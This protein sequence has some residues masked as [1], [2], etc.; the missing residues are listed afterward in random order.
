MHLSPEDIAAAE[1]CGIS[2][3][4]ASD[5]Q[6]QRLAMQRKVFY[7]AGAPILAT[8]GDGLFETAGTLLQLI[9]EGRQQQH[10]L[11]QWLEPPQSATGA[12]PEAVPEPDM[13]KAAPRA[14][15]CLPTPATAE[16]LVP[17]PKRQLQKRRRLDMPV[18][19]APEPAALPQMVE[20]SPD[21]EA[22]RAESEGTS[23]AELLV[24][25]PKRQLQKQRRLD[26]PVPAAPELAA[27]PQMVEVEPLPDGEA[28]RAES[29]GT[30]VPPTLS[31]TSGR[32]AARTP[33]TRVDVSGQD[34][35]KRWL[36][37][38]AT[39]RGRAGKHWSTRQR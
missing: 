10:D 1:A 23:V 4:P 39:R 31:F 12:M 38:G 11:S 36:M 13:V 25:S 16:L 19:A 35:G 2:F 20:P 22:S 30:S 21:G 37:A 27:L 32:I 24:P 26:M 8:R 6:V 15:A 18:P 17:S 29:E 34:R 5:A 3:L 7:R 14:P 9:D 33:A 28:S